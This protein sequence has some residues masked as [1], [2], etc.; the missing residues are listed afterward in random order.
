[1]EGVERR[2]G[3]VWVCPAEAV[4]APVVDR[5]ALRYVLGQLRCVRRVIETEAEAPA[6]LPVISFPPDLAR[7]SLE[8]GSAL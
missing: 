6:G 3:T 2:Y 7:R 8:L 4:F 1:M 5:A